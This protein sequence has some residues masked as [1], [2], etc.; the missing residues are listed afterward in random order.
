MIDT[1]LIRDINNV[2][3]GD[4]TAFARFLTRG[5][6]IIK[7]ASGSSSEFTL[8]KRAVS[9][10]IA[11]LQEGEISPSQAQEW[12]SFVRRGYISNA[13]G[14]PSNTDEP[15]KPININYDTNAEEDIAAVISRLDEINDIVDGDISREELRQLL[16][17]LNT[18]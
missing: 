4:Y 13:N 16:E 10:I 6:E 15:I 12:A 18:T 2:I 17:R 9:R 3:Q 5:N 11:A 14:R 8:T 7:I 1:D